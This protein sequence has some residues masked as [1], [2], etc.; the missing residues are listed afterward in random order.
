MARPTAAA[1][2]YRPHAP[3]GGSDRRAWTRFTPTKR[4]VD[5]VVLVSVSAFFLIEAALP[6]LTWSEETYHRFWVHAPWLMAHVIG[7]SIALIVGPW[8]F[9]IALRRP[10][11]A[12]HRWT[13]RLYLGGVLLAGASGLY[14][15]FY[16]PMIAF[17]AGLLALDVAWL[18]ST[19]M[20]YIAVRNRRIA[21]HREWMI[22]S[23]VLTL[24]FVSFR[25][26]LLL[27]LSLEL[28]D[29]R[30]VIP[31]VGW[32]S[33]LGPLLAVELVLRR[34]R[35]NRAHVLCPLSTRSKH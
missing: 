28:G 11:L 33:F 35:S 3:S 20:A 16:A 21:Q 34:A 19:T 25:F 4:V 14:L 13:G 17:A 18:T 5:W 6:Y 7:G 29:P 10:L 15:V 2:T 8:Q 9:W 30:T 27:A 24:V 31:I 1:P 32:V 23:Y 12:V 26:W 22:R